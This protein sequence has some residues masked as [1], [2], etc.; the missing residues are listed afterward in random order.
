VIEPPKQKGGTKVMRKRHPIDINEIFRGLQDQ[1]EAKLTF[2]RKMI[3]H[4]GAK[5][6]ATELAWTEMLSTYLPKR[7][8]AA[9]A[10]ILDST[11][12][13]SDEIDIVVFDRQYS[14]FILHQNGVAY[15]PA[16][17]VYAV[18]E[19]KQDLSKRSL[20][21]AETKAESVRRLK[22]TSV[23][24]PHAGGTYP[25]KKPARILAGIVAL[26]G[27]LSKQDKDRLANTVED[28]T[29]NFGCSLLGKTSFRLPDHHPWEENER[30]YGL[31]HSIGENSLID[32]FLNLVAELQKV[33][34]VP[35]LD[36]AGYTKRNV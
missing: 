32:F 5:G 14:P 4:P 9:K 18:I 15:I 34:T 12:E 27:K 13:I 28:R 10:F 2:N 23:P 7:Y 11:G 35:A 20:S 16:E 26:D 29:L 30:P 19:V 31:E 25:A 36:I 24:I 33:G 1:M 6:S 3:R 21:Y 8:C 17:C 22:R